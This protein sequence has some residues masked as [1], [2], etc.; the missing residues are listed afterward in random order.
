M[1]GPAQFAKQQT[2][3]TACIEQGSGAEINPGDAPPYYS[4]LSAEKTTAALLALY[5]RPPAAWAA[6]A[7]W[8]ENRDTIEQEMA[9]CLPSSSDAGLR[10]RVLFGIASQAR[11][12][13]REVDDPQ[14]WVARCANL[15]SRRVALKLKK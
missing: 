8:N 14:A 13:C 12:F 7:L 6:V 1:N 4:A 10:E 15:E 9:R 3:R 2:S 5:D 11:F